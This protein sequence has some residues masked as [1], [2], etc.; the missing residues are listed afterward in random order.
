MIYWIILTCIYTWSSI[1]FSDRNIDDEVVAEIKYDDNPISEQ[2]TYA[3]FQ[4]ILSLIFSNASNAKLSSHDLVEKALNYSIE[5]HLL[6]KRFNSVTAYKSKL[7]FME[8]LRAR[9]YEKIANSITEEQLKQEYKMQLQNQSMSEKVARYEKQYNGVRVICSSRE[10]A[11][12]VLWSLQMG[13][14]ID[15]IVEEFNLASLDIVTDRFVLTEQKIRSSFAKETADAIITRNNQDKISGVL[16]AHNNTW[17]VIYLIELRS[18][19]NV[20]SYRN[21]R[22]GILQILIQQKL[23]EQLNSVNNDIEHHDSNLS[24]IHTDELEDEDILYSTKI[25]N[26]N[27]TWSDIKQIQLFGI[28]NACNMTLLHLKITLLAYRLLNDKKGIL[29]YLNLLAKFEAVKEHIKIS[30]TLDEMRDSFTDFIREEF[31]LGYYKTFSSFAVDEASLLKDTCKVGEY[32]DMT[33]FALPNHVFAKKFGGMPKSDIYSVLQTASKKLII[34]CIISDMKV[35][36]DDFITDKNNLHLL[37]EYSVKKKMKEEVQTLK[38]RSDITIFDTDISL[39]KI[40]IQN[41]VHVLR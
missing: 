14:S 10:I 22:T 5:L 21:A 34:I 1:I 9:L 15:N 16:K 27:I 31:T 12:D 8:L 23:M 6:N 7:F 25:L 28:D 26:I 30:L 20:A 4:N 40:V 36:F 18:F 17:E 41:L 39:D 13:K 33:Y 11:E 3:E 24:K 35:D 37:R 2:V 19:L 32:T 38:E 29:D